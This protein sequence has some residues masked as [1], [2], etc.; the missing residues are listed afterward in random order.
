MMPLS[1]PMAAKLWVASH[2][3]LLLVF[4]KALKMKVSKIS[5]CSEDSLRI[6]RSGKQREEELIKDV[7]GALGWEGEDRGDG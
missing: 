7:G 6:E 3:F 1:L 5:P 2:E 4:M